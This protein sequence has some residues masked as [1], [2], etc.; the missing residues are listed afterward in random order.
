MTAYQGGKKRIGKQIYTEILKWDNPDNPLPY[1]EPFCGM[2]GVLIHFAKDNNRSI[3][4]SDVNKDIV[5][6]WKALQ[7][8]WNPPTTCDRET[9]EKLKK[10]NRHSA[11]RGFIGVVCSF[12]AMFFKGGFRTHSKT[13]NFLECG[14]R[15]L[16]ETVK[17][18]KEVEFLKGCSYDTHSPHGMLIYC[19]PPYVGNNVANDTFQ[20]FDHE[21]FWNKMRE[22]SQN[23]IVIISEKIA[24]PD[25]ECIWALD[26]KVSFLNQSDSTNKKKKYTEKLFI[27][28]SLIR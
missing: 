28:N 11:R 5:M 6:M 12:S 13:H 23:N 15:T 2:C 22:W 27:H 19:D 17:H 18:M 16:K 4:A 21:E 26:Y 3:I 7:K 20:S 10:T 24:P 25:F 8:G 14:T 9:Y 1:F